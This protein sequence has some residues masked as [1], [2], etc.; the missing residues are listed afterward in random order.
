M[1]HRKEIRK[2]L[3]AKRLI[4]NALFDALVIF[5]VLVIIG[6]LM[7]AFN[8]MADAFRDRA[9]ILAKRYIY[10]INELGLIGI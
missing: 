5:S 1:D 4:L 6:I 2:S 9:S 7:I 3:N 8:F 10:S